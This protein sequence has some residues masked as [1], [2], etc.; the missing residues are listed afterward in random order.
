M[1]HKALDETPIVLTR[2]G[3]EYV[4]DGVTYQDATGALLIGV[5]NGCGCGS[6]GDTL[7]MAADLAEADFDNRERIFR[8]AGL[9]L[10]T[11]AGAGLAYGFLYWLDGGGL[12]EHG[13]G[14]MG[15]WLTRR[16]ED[17]VRLA[18]EATADPKPGTA[19][20]AVR[21]SGERG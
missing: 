20:A 12:L 10:D 1:N 5:L 18:R 13:G 21:P 19:P 17:F 9:D 7:R 16:G 3:E 14:I 15:A 4:L 8:E 2:D 11:D 6:P